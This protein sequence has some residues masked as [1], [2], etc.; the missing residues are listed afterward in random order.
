[1]RQQGRVFPLF[2][3]LVLLTLL[4]QAAAQVVV[5]TFG[6]RGEVEDA[7]LGEVMAELRREIGLQTGLEV[8]VGDLVPPGIAG[9]LDTDYAYLIAE[10]GGGRYALSGEVRSAEAGGAQ[11]PYSLSILIADE[12][13]AR[14]SDIFSEPFNTETLGDVVARLAAEVAQFVS[15]LG[16]LETGEAELFIS[17]TPSEAAVLINDREVGVTSQLDVLMLKPGVYKLELRKEG[18]LPATR[19]VTLSAERPELI[20][21]VLTALVGGSIQISSVPRAEVFI[22]GVSEGLS[23]LTVQLRPGTRRVRLQRPGFETLQL[24][25][26]VQNYRVYQVNQQLVPVFE[27]M[28]FWDPSEIGLLTV[29]GVLRS[30]GFS[31]DIRPGVHKIEARV[32]AQRYAFSVEV[33]EPGV[34]ELDVLGQRLIPLE[35]P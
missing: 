1:M 19:T 32:G 18:F 22:D 9:S 30:G 5:P 11:A 20:N 25:V 28:L 34:Y 15:P 21:I 6:T 10:L 26:P 14:S 3:S 4:T 33:A 31:P 29:D 7:L 16:V 35:S 13:A 8:D 17:S 2:L 27:N 24:E 23:P 12:E